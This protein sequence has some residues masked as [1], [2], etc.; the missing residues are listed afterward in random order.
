MLGIARVN[1]TLVFV[2]E[3]V[4]SGANHRECKHKTEISIAYPGWGY[5]GLAASVRRLGL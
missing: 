3:C 4:F 2:Y 1:W 5:D